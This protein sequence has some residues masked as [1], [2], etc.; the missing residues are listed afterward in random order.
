MSS[1]KIQ[2]RVRST[3]KKLA[4]VKKKE[5]RD[6][7]FI[8]PHSDLSQF[9]YTRSWDQ[10]LFVEVYGYEVNIPDMPPKEEIVNYGKSIKEQIFR[11]TL[12]PQDLQYWPEEDREAFIEREHHRRKHGMWFY[13]KGEPVYIPGLFYYFL[14][15]WPLATGRPTRF[16]MG[17]WKF[18]IIWMHTVLTETIFGLLVFKCRRIGDTE[19][20]LCMIYEYATR[21]RNTISQMYDCR[22]EKDMVKTWKRL[23]KSHKRMIWFMK[24]VVKNEDP[25]SS[26]EFSEKSKLDNLSDSFID[27][28]GAYVASDYEYPTLESEI[29]YYT[30]EGGA[31][32]ARI[33][34]E[35]VDEFGKF[36]QI[37][38]EEL[39]D[40]SK[41]ALE[42]DR[43]GE[44][45]GKCL[46]TSTI[47]DLTNGK[48]LEVAEK[49]WEQSDPT[50]LD[51]QGRTI[52]GMIRIVRGA[53]DRAETDRWGFVDEE[54]ER[55]KIQEHQAFLIKNKQW[56]KL[57][58]YKRQ[59]CLTIEDVMSNISKGS[60]FDL[61]KINNRH[62][63]LIFNEQDRSVRGNLDWVDGKKPIPG[64]PDNTN[65]NCKAFFTPDPENG[66]WYFT[67]HPKDWGLEENKQRASASIPMPG[68]I[69]Y[70]SCGIDPV[71]YKDNLDAKNRSLAGLAVKR[72]LDHRI[73]STNNRDLYDEQ[74]NTIDLGRFFKTNKYCC[75]Y[76]HRHE[77]PNDNYNDWLLTLVYFGT[78]FLI[79]K[80]HSAAFE[81]YL[82]MLGFLE[83]YMEK[84]GLKNYK[85][86]EETRGLTSGE[87]VIENYFS[88]IA[89]YISEFANAID[90]PQVTKQLS[91]MEQ[92]TRGKHDL[93][94]AIGYTEMASNQKV[95]LIQ[96]MN[97]YEE[98]MSENVEYTEVIYHD[99]D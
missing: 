59:N 11:K 58:K 73:D 68:N 25:S 62:N 67:H 70:F 56:T 50:K 6:K 21:V 84:S 99:N 4:G 95:K 8:S 9:R 80:N 51:P 15:Y 94:V 38:P 30:N 78:D 66:R 88:A 2:Q 87:K 55:K 52:S 14:N 81:T 20:G 74:G 22:T 13:I 57:I 64:D 47:E 92:E 7:G 91:T 43:E 34:R 5:D 79:E 12:I 32:G 54:A 23:K 40:L 24:P 42:D 97:H 60:P 33:D 44:I 10:G 27:E 31:D 53:L 89:S 98:Q 82:E 41:K 45:I 93:G 96:K 76:W 18:F 49:M 19:K 71:S 69:Q 85:G 35:Y 75:T 46:Y 29:S 72:N 65:K 28:T 63:E 26:Y 3:K 83:Y 1:I 90:N 77:N 36:N 16:H 39:H 17:D 86:R 48:T 61:E 37:N